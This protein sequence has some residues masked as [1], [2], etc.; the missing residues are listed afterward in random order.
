MTK[1]LLTAW[2]SYP[3]SGGV[4]PDAAERIASIPGPDGTVMSVFVAHG[5]DGWRCIAPV[6]ESVADATQS[7]PS[8][9]THLGDRCRSAIDS[10]SFGD[11]AGGEYLPNAVIYDALAGVAVR[12]ELHTA[13]GEIFP[14]VL[15]EGRFWGWFPPQARGSLRPTL[16]GYAADGTVVGTTQAM[17]PHS[18]CC[19][20]KHQR[21][22]PH[23][24][25]FPDT[26]G[27][28]LRKC[29][30]PDGAD[31]SNSVVSELDSVFVV[32][33]VRLD[34]IRFYCEA[35]VFK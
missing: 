19:T 16:F 10:G 29:H 13:A 1:D 25:L 26:T 24:D 34:S 31:Q 15:A 21:S 9:F 4:N 8:D 32:V 20:V 3:D 11:G 28:L 7:G 12:A 18:W 33:V 6:F 22:D 14:T 30:V 17:A 23:E 2:Q 5:S 27:E 35:A